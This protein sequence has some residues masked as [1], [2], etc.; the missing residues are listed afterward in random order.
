MT[1]PIRFL[2][3]REVSERTGLSKPTMYRLIRA[4]EFPPAIPISQGTVAWPDYAVDDWI[5]AQLRAHGYAIPSE[6]A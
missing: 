5:A 3:Q 6:A 2:R 4:G 1:K